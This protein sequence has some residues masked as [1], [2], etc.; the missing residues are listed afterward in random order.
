MKLKLLFVAV[1]GEWL[2]R[3]WSWCWRAAPW[4]ATPAA[5]P[6]APGAPQQPALLQVLQARCPPPLGGKRPTCDGPDSKKHTFPL[7]VYDE[8]ADPYKTISDAIALAK[9]ESK[10][11]LVMWGENWC[12]FCL[13]PGGHSGPRAR[14]LAA[15]EERLR[16]GARRSGQGQDFNKNQA[17]AESFG[18]TEWTPRPD[19]KMMGAPSLCI[20]DPETGKTV[21]NIDPKTGNLEGVL[22]G[23][24]MV[25]KP[26]MLNRLF[27]E[28]IIKQFLITWRPPAKP[29]Q[30]AMN[31]ATGAA[32]RDSKKILALFIM[33]GD[34]A[35]EK[36]SAWMSRLDAAS[37]LGNSFITVKI[38]T[39]RM[40]GGREMLVAAA[41]KPVLPP[42][43]CV[44]D[45]AGKPLS[46]P[47]QFTALPKTD[48]KI[49]E[50]IK[51]C[52]RRR[53]SATRTRP[54]LCGSLKDAA[55]AQAEPK[56]G[57]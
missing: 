10:R 31:E 22:G 54:C 49:D 27:D 42:F 4:P 21:G 23:N 46:P 11:V 35:C 55:L 33:G 39:E 41:G 50:F 28:K 53:R 51:G 48:A 57:P 26:M 45:S 16:L 32:K 44:L 15:G 8:N 18:V 12:Q 43:L 38:D 25:A 5:S 3:V 19:G 30:N 34:D 24:D 6:G 29:A 2:W 37:A 47:V 9:S 13:Y 52:P 1:L 40:I 7:N 36:A 14:M 20:I 17:I 56:K